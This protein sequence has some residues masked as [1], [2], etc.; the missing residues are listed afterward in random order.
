MTERTLIILG[1]KLAESEIRSAKYQAAAEDTF[2]QLEHTKAALAE[3]TK[4]ASRLE[5]VECELDSLRGEL[6]TA[7]LEIESLKSGSKRRNK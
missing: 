5:Q 7:R 1:Q 3:A 6:A 2:K 4:T